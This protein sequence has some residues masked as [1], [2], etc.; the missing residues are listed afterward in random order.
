LADW[1]RLARPK[2]WTK[3]LLLF[4]ALLFSG[5][6]RSPEAWLAS[7][8]AFSAFVLLSA[9]VYALND[10]SDAEADR[11]HAVK[12]HRPVAAGRV[13]LV[14]AA[15]LSGVWAA[16]GLGLAAWLGLRELGREVASGR[17]APLRS[18]PSRTSN[19]IRAGG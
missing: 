4:A 13:G 1:L 2:Q 18:R 3:N 6:L 11:R 14:E 5:R 10:L 8:T 12:R 17:H 16:L 7:L 9:S 15:L 19:A